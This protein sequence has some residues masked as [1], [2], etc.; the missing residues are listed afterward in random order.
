MIDYNGLKASRLSA[1]DFSVQIK[2]IP[3]TVAL[4]GK[5]PY[6]CIIKKFIMI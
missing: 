1:R 3:S 5:I 2:I 6:L 4:Y